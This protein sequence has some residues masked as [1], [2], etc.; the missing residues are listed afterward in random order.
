[1][2]LAELCERL[3]LLATVARIWALKRSGGHHHKRQ[4]GPSKSRR[5]LCSDDVRYH[6]KTLVDKQLVSKMLKAPETA[7]LSTAKLS[8]KSTASI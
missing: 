6:T 8:T 3:Q 1:M 7:S 5:H 4:Q 2:L